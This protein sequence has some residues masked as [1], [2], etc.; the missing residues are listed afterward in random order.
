MRV[1]YYVKLTVV[2]TEAVM[3]GAGDMVPMHLACGDT[4][5]LGLSELAERS[6]GR[7]AYSLDDGVS[8]GAV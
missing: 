1:I 7:I 6:H 4:P 3:S 8:A 5:A 2:R